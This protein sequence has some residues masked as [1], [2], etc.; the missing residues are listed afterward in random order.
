MRHRTLILTFALALL[1]LSAAVAGTANARAAF[2]QH[3]PWYANAVSTEGVTLITDTLAPG[4]GSAKSSPS[5]ITDTLAPGGGSAAKPAPAFVTDTLAPGGG[6]VTTPGSRLTVDRLIRGDGRTQSP[7]YQFV[8]DT[9]APGGGVSASSPT[10]GSNGFGWSDAGI[11]SAVTL[12]LL[13]LVLIA[14]GL[15]VHRRRT[16]AV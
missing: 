14:S 2:G 5:F 13:V 12:G 8:T 9:L 1:A 10:P 11:G 3:D 7:S 6:S 4:G 15:A 16:V